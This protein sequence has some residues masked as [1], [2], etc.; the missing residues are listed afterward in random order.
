MSYMVE[1]M[2]DEDGGKLAF[3]QIPAA[4]YDASYRTSADVCGSVC[5]KERIDLGWLPV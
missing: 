2:E 3:G 4:E 5:V 1:I